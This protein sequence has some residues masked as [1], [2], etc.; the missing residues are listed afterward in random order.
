MS[1]GV[2]SSQ[3][4]NNLY[5][6]MNL[7]FKKHD[8]IAAQNQSMVNLNTSEMDRAVNAYE[9]LYLDFRENSPQVYTTPAPQRGT[10]EFNNELDEFTDFAFSSVYGAQEEN[11]YEVQKG[12][13]LWKITRTHYDNELADEEIAAQVAKIIEN[14]NITTPDLLE[15]GQKIDLSSLD[16]LSDEALEVLQL[17]TD[18]FDYATYIAIDDYESIENNYNAQREKVGLDFDFMEGKDPQNEEEYNAQVLKLAQ[19]EVELKDTDKDGKLSPSE[20]ILPEVVDYIKTPT[21]QAVQDT[22]KNGKFD[23]EEEEALTSQQEAYDEEM[24]ASIRTKG[25]RMFEIID[26]FMT[27]TDEEGNE[28]KVSDGDDL[29]SAQELAAYYLHLDEF[30]GEGKEKLRDGKINIDMTAEYSDF[31]INQVFSD[32]A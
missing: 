11:I 10:E 4:G 25:A 14:N 8:I 18:M 23:D 27:V 5:S 1:N 26:N 32:E 16:K 30:Q 21:I 24:Q 6:D 29:L 22:N 12:D 31:L 15:I 3:Q 28:I 9:N 7:W 2:S 13:S 20:Y 19:Q 17:Y